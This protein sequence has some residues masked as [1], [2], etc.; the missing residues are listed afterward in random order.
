[1]ID[2]MWDRRIWFRLTTL[3]IGGGLLIWLPFEES[4]TSGV[5]LF[6][7]VICMLTLLYFSK[8]F[9]VGSRVTLIRSTL[10]GLLSGLAVSPLAIFLMAF[11]SGLHGH[12]APDFTPA[13]VDLVLSLFPYFGL[14]GVSAGVGLDLLCRSCISKILMD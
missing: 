11:K 3:L 5:V 10:V 2:V 9:S 8:R 14:G 4:S 1:M 13:Q 7:I 6:S 12:G